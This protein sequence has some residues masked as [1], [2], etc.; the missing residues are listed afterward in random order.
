[1]DVPHD[2]LER[3]MARF[4]ATCEEAGVRVTHQRVEVFREIARSGEHP[5]AEP[6]FRRLRQR[7]PTLSLDT[8]YR[9]LWFLHDLGLITTFGLPR[10][11]TRFDPNVAPHQ[12][13]VCTRCGAV[14]DF[15][16]PRL[17]ALDLPPQVAAFGEVQS[18]HLE[19]RGVCRACLANP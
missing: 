10:E 8:V 14:E 16:L 13:F 17:E 4:F 2:E 3:R 19:L 1:M 5:D 11:R 9:T 15:E 6:L 18:R 7:L 12:H